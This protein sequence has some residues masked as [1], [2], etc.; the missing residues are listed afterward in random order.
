MG[1]LMNR[2]DCSARS[3]LMPIVYGLQTLRLNAANDVNNKGFNWSESNSVMITMA[4]YAHSDNIG[5][6]EY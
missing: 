4:L 3:T 2:G 6:H 1:A 5:I